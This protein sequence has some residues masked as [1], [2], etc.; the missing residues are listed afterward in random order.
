MDRLIKIY[1]DGIYLWVI[2]KLPRWNI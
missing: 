1:E 2:K